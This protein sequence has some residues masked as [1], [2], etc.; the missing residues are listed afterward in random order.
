MGLENCRLT[1]F[2][3]LL[4]WVAFPI[5][6]AMPLPLH[7]PQFT[8]EIICLLMLFR[9]ILVGSPSKILLIGPFDHKDTGRYAGQKTNWNDNGS[10]KLDRLLLFVRFPDLPDDKGLLAH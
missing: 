6:S 1:F 2:D 4:D 7:S 5:K 10:D 9:L 3:R 8:G